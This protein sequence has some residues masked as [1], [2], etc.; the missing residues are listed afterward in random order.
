[1]MATSGFQ[2]IRVHS[3]SIIP[4]ALRERTKQNFDMAVEP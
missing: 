1:M 2:H 4:R 3:H